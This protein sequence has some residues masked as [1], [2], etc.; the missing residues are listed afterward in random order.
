V[1][2][3]PIPSSGSIDDIIRSSLDAARHAGHIEP[4]RH[5]VIAAGAPLYV[6]GNTNFIKVERVG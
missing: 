3:I 6:P 2:P 1:F 5:V 4:G